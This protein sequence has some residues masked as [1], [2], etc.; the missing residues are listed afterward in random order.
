MDGINKIHTF[1]NYSTMKKIIFAIAISAIVL[2][3]CSKDDSA[4]SSYSEEIALSATPA[5][6]LTYVNENYPD[7]NVTEVLKFT[8]SDTSYS[9]LL[10]TYEF[11]VF[12]NY[13]AMSGKGISSFNCDSI[14]GHHHGDSLQNPSHGGHHGSG[15]HGSGHH[16]GGHHGGGHH[17]NGIALDS[18]PAIITEYLATNYSGFTPHNGWYD[19]ICPV[20]GVIN[21]MIDSAHNSHYK[22]VFAANGEFFAQAQRIDSTSIPTPIWLTLSSTYPLYSARFKAELFILADNTKLYRMFLHHAE[23]RISLFLN[24][25]GIVLCE[26]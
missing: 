5:A 13:L 8:N 19:T 11:L 10:D 7:A 23:T 6:I 4:V 12:N 25:D 9:V 18:L 17:Q 16:G 2:T 14:P 22:I 26:Q 3:S 1:K 15:H 20:G 24:E 21:V